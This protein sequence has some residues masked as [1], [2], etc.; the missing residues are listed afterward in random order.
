MFWINNKLVAHIG[1]T[2]SIEG[3]YWPFSRAGV[4]TKTSREGFQPDIFHSG[5]NVAFVG[6]QSG[7]LLNNLGLDPELEASHGK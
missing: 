1:V 5:V 6:T 3:S 2:I 7:K 4:R